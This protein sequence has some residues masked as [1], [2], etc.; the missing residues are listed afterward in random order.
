MWFTTFLLTFTFSFS[1]LFLL[2]RLLHSGSLS[3]L[4]LLAV[5]VAQVQKVTMV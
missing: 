2:F 5:V 3:Q 4:D 1:L